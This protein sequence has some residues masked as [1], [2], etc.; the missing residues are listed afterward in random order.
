VAMSFD[1]T[2]FDIILVVLLAGIMVLGARRGVAGLVAGLVAV[3]AW[4]I[5][6]VLGRIE[7]LIGFVLALV[8]GWFV[9]GTLARNAYA[10][11]FISASSDAARTIL[12]GLGGTLMGLG[13][14]VALALSFPITSTPSA[15]PGAFSYPSDA[16]PSWLREGVN[17][18][19]IQRALSEPPSRGGL[20]LWRGSAFFK[21]FAVPDRAGN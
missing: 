5:V 1:F 20:G 18:S 2:W 4:P 9:V 19:A 8:A 17:R 13:L 7:P 10:T 6:N 3:F 15:G 11:G 12:G 16:L 21:L 14:V